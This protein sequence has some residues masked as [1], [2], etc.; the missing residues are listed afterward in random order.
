MIQVPS[1][2]VVARH[3]NL[4]WRRSILGHDNSGTMEY[5]A[6]R[7][8]YGARVIFNLFSHGIREY[9]PKKHASPG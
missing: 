4:C 9:S 7:T 5:I 8:P 2:L 3:F 6:F 1:N